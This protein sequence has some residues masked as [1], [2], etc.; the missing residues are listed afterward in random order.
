[1]PV[2]AG[3]ARP[4]NHRGDGQGADESCRHR[5]GAALFPASSGRAGRSQVPTRSDLVSG[6]WPIVASCGTRTLLSGIA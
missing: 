1:M 2:P 6:L 4:A 5:R 3:K